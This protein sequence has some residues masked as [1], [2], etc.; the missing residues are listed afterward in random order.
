MQTYVH[1]KHPYIFYF[2]P[3]YSCTRETVSRI[4]AFMA[5]IIQLAGG[6]VTRL[7]P[8]QFLTIMPL[9]TFAFVVRTSKT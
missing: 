3:G 7:E 4:A 2:T 9:T 6:L 8:L 5:M 1:S